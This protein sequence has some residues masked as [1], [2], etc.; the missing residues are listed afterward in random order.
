MLQNPFMFCM[1]EIKEKKK[2]LD[3][4]LDFQNQ[5]VSVSISVL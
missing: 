5:Q 4:I 1:P 3:D 2:K